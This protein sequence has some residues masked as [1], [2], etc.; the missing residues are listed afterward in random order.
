MKSVQRTGVIR[1]YDM[2]SVSVRIGYGLLLFC[3][4]RN[5]TRISARHRP[6]AGH[7]RRGYQCGNPFSSGTRI[8]IRPLQTLVIVISSPFRKPSSSSSMPLMM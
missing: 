2:H 1:D 7:H 3:C 6:G 5:D 4:C 8:S